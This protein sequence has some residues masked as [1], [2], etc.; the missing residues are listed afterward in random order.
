MLAGQKTILTTFLLCLA[1]TMPVRAA[2]VAPSPSPPAPFSAVVVS[3]PLP[4]QDDATLHDVRFVG[5]GVCWAVGDHGVIWRSADGGWSW[6]LIDAGVRTTWRSICFLSDQVGWIAGGGIESHTRQG[7]GMVI[8]TRDGGKTWTQCASPILTNL[9]AVR[10]FNLQQGVAIGESSDK[11]PTG[12]FI[13]DDGGR[14]WQS[15]PGAKRSGWRT[16]DFISPDAGSAAGLN[17]MTTLFTRERLLP[18]RMPPSSPRAFRRLKLGPDGRGWLVGDGA[19]ALWTDNGG[20]VWQE[21]ATPLPRELADMSD[22]HAVECRG[23]NVWCAGL[24]GSVIWHTPDAGQSWKP[25]YTPVTVPIYAVS[26]A[27]DARGCAVGALGTVLSTRDGGRLWEAVRGNDR[28]LA[29]LDVHTQGRETSLAL[30]ARESAEYGHRSALLIPARRELTPDAHSHLDLPLRVED[31][32]VSL[33]A[34]G[35]EIDWRLPIALPDVERDRERMLAEWNH[36]TEGRFAQVIMESLVCRLRTWRPSVVV[37]DE[38]SGGDAAAVI[39][40]E[41]VAWAIKLAADPAQFAA[42]QTLAGLKP[43]Q[44]SKLAVRMSQPTDGH[45]A[46]DRHEYLSRL[47]CTVEEAAI[48]AESRWAASA[49]PGGDHEAY[50]VAEC[51]LDL[52]NPDDA[53]KSLF[54]GLSL[55]PGSDARRILLP[56]DEQR[57]AQRRALAEKQRNL[58]AYSAAYLDDPRHATQVIAQ[59]N[60]LVEEMPADQAA[61][62][63]IRLADEYRRRAKWTQLEATLIELAEK[64]P[65]LPAAQNGMY[66]LLQLWT[67]DELC[68]QRVR[69]QLVRQPRLNLNPTAVRE[70]IVRAHERAQ[71]GNALAADLNADAGAQVISTEEYSGRVSAGSGFN[72]QAGVV[73]EYRGRAVLLAQRMQ[74]VAPQFYDTLDVQLTVAALMN[75]RGGE[76]LA[77]EQYKHYRRQGENAATP[78]APS[79]ELTLVGSVKLPAKKTVSCRRTAEAPYLDGVLSDDCWAEASEIALARDMGDGQATPAGAFALMAYD[80]NYLYIAGSFPRAPG[81]PADPPQLAGRTHDADLSRFDRLGFFLDVDRD[82]GTYYSF[83]VDQRGQTA[84]ECWHNPRWNPSWHVAAFGDAD[85]WRIEIAIPLEELAARVPRP[86]DTWGVGVIRA[87]PATAVESWGQPAGLLPRPESFGVVRFD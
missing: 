44:V 85:H 26:F 3:T 41:A 30:I 7:H 18:T 45:F 48:H 53:H 87:I 11:H 1:A 13:T 16:A 64:Y 33:G 68:W 69:E 63:L 78:F 74:K 38:P 42:Q 59:I 51:R 34:A 43:W 47:E 50:R 67:S 9:C 24:P 86:G 29:L 17:G 27:D 56:R 82:C 39:L 31:A 8:A 72:W 76:R 73:D 28:R 80:S 35:G 54:S 40:N 22:F 60:H 6:Q 15:I 55:L 81:A 58:R 62:Q 20:L 32:A 66:A 37:V 12:I 49:G 36:R 5:N 79:G 21:P 71:E 83:H 61:L 2:D 57:D 75:H 52:P 77:A 4:I 70:R 46:L 14:N 65:Q 23:P 19:L 25:Q 10:F 84:E